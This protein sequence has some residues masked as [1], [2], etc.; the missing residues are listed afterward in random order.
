MGKIEIKS[1]EGKVLFSY[2]KENNTLKD[3]LEVAVINSIKLRGADLQGANLESI[4]LNWIDL[5]FSNLKGANLKNANLR[6]SYL[7]GANLSHANLQSADLRG[8]RLRDADLQGANLDFSCLDFSCK[9]TEAITDERLRIQLCNHLLQWIKNGKNV[10]EKE[11]EIFEFC[12]D[13]AN[14][15]HRNDVEKFE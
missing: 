1:I 15:F 2:E 9:S 5:S 13:Y 8:A 3:T 11:R 7:Y 4:N 10:T 6:H 14:K 12:K